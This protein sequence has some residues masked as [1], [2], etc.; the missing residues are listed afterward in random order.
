[1]D[2]DNLLTIKQISKNIGHSTGTIRKIINNEYY[3]ISSMLIGGIIF[4]NKED[5]FRIK[6]IIKDNISK[7]SMNLKN[8][9][10]HTNLENNSKS[11]SLLDLNKKIEEFNNSVKDSNKLDYQRII[12]ITNNIENINKK[13]S[14]I[15]N[16]LNKLIKE[17][18]INIENTNVIKD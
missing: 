11:I 17:F 12:L 6:K 13:I 10:N 4:I 14:N 8:N 3:G 1:M 15:E 2:T 5:V 16:I 18:G 7:R 9:Q